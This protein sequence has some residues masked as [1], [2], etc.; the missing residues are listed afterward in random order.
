ML[1]L[2]LKIVER[3][4]D[5]AQYA[6]KA[7][8]T[9]HP[10]MKGNWDFNHMSYFLSVMTS[11]YIFFFKFA[12]WPKSHKFQFFKLEIENIFLIDWFGGPKPLTPE[13]YLHPNM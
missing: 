12:A 1:L 6:Q 4:S 8:F 3:K 7:L 5:E 11:P 13:Q 9:K 10:E 2:Q